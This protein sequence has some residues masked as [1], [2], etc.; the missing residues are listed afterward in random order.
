MQAVVLSIGDEL[1]L[2][3]NVDTNSAFLSGQ[4]AAMGVMT[5]YHQ[6]VADDQA[7]IAQ[8][9]VQASQAAPWVLITGGLGPTLD[10]LTRQA[11]A[12]AMGVE[13]V[14]DQTSL[15][16]LETFFACRNRVM[17]ANNRVQAMK[18][19]G[20]VMLPNSCG[21]A[22]GI[23]ATLGRAT[24]Y[25]TPG[26]PKEMLAMWRQ[27]ID[28][29]IRRR[30]QIES[31]GSQ[32]TILT[33]KAN[34]FGIGESSLGQMLGDLMDRRRNP[35]VGTTVSGGIVS[36]R[37][38]SDFPS[39][40]QAKEELDRTLAD[41]RRVTGDFFFGLE[42]ETLQASL[43]ELLAK[44]RRQLATAE[45]CTGGMVAQA[46]TDVPGSS[47]HYLGGWVTYANAM[48][49]RELGVAWQLIERCGAV[50]C[51]VALAM[52]QGALQNSGADLAVSLTGVAGPGG[53]TSEKPVGLVWVALADGRSNQSFAIRLDLGANDRATTRDRATKAALQMA[54]F[55]LLG[56]SAS[57]MTWGRLPT[58]DESAT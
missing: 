52:A 34:T 12:Q 26:V 5:L 4:L 36:V 23:Q 54:R 51:P 16:T 44:E 15:Q 55:H 3:Q 13:L 43:V 7:A 35:M 20:A 50:S 38:R 31:A 49:Q 42:D 53:G 32:R 6:T 48:K 57:Q 58:A 11:L 37:I 25:V 29:E 33:L 47:E 10:D 39:A 9:I 46:I 27:T 19:A 40:D 21:T 41:V 22:P 2:G 1:V 18:P 8:A 14:L 24:L 30:I 28:P 45:S 56:R 17:T